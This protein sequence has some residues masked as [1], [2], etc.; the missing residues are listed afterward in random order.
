MIAMAAALLILGQPVL[1]FMVPAG[2]PSRDEVVSVVWQLLLVGSACMLADGAQNVAMGALRGL[3]FGRQTIYEAMGGYRLV[4][5]PLAWWLGEKLNLGALGVW[6]GVG[7]D[8]HV[9]A[10][11]LL[12]FLR[13]NTRTRRS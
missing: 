10:A 12:F 2:T 1:Q 8:L 5:V 11:L 3:G 9:S 4:G 7:V 6:I 13:A